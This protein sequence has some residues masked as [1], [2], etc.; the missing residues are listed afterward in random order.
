MGIE[1]TAPALAPTLASMT[2]LAVCMLALMPAAA[3]AAPVNS[4]PIYATQPW[5]SMEMVLLLVSAL[6]LAACGGAGLML[7]H[8]RRMLAHVI[9]QRERQD[10]LLRAM[11]MASP[12]PY[13]I[14]DAHL[15][16]RGCN[17]AFEH[18]MEVR[19]DA[20]IGHSAAEL[21]PGLRR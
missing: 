20:I 10:E 11:R 18:Y 14:K 9:R 6:L 2:P 8:T 15:L 4:P 13:F 21:F 1:A 3:F 5:I 17:R 12:V 7:L 19:E 16:Y